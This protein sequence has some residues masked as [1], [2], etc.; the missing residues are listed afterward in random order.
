MYRKLLVCLLMV[1]G[2]GTGCTTKYTQQSI[3][4][5][6]G[7]YSFERALD[8]TQAKHAQFYFE[9]DIDDTNRRNCI[10][11]TDRILG[12]LQ[13]NDALPTI[14]VMDIENPYISGNTLYLNIQDWN[15][16]DYATMVLLTVSGQGSHYGLAYG[17][18]NMLC[19]RFGWN[20]ETS[21]QFTLTDDLDVYDLN[22]LC[23]RNNFVS[24]SGV[25]AALC[26]N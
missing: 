24:E 21:A 17:Y 15:S 2:L 19:D 6:D 12:E 13:S 22:Y 10:D 4:Y 20:S 26:K 25:T 14:C 18:A 5:A 16:A 23:F 7:S 8:F 9:T 11:A 1:V 3:A